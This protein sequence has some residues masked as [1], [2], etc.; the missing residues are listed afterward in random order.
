M[1][2]K[3]KKT[4][5]K[6]S[7]RIFNHKNSSCN[8]KYVKRVYTHG[9]KSKPSYKICKKCGEL[10]DSEFIKKRFNSNRRYK[11]EKRK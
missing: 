3:I 9:R 6:I 8:H 2:K 10:L 4:I 11:N 5:K 7:K 1:R